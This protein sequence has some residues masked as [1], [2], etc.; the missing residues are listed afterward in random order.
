MK[1]QIA[2][3]SLAVALLAGCQ[4]SDV[5][6]QQS[7]SVMIEESQVVLKSSLWIDRM[8]SIGESSSSEE[9]FHAALSLESINELP[10]DLEVVS[11]TI[12]QGNE[13]WLIESEEIDIRTHSAN[14]WEL[15]VS[16]QLPISPDLPADIAIQ[17]N[18]KG[19]EKWLVDHD[20]NIDVVY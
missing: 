13:T 1:K 7:S 16:W 10:A 19:Q 2:L 9:N 11:V 4:N 3:A 18:N 17:L 6:W 15:A 12:K 20:V 5:N 14:Q 8:P